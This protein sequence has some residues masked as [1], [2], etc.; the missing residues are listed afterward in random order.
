VSASVCEPVVRKDKSSILPKGDDGVDCEG[1]LVLFIKSSLM[2]SIQESQ[3]GASG[4]NSTGS[5]L[6]DQESFCSFLPHNI[7]QVFNDRNES[8]TYPLWHFKRH[9]GTVL[10]LELTSQIG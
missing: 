3:I 9:V 7:S 1:S 2:N 8:L 4:S 5:T 10:R 6:V